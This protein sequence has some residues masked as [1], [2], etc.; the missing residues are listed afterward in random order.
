MA[1]EESFKRVMSYWSER[2]VSSAEVLLLVGVDGG[3]QEGDC[4]YEARRT[5][6]MEW[7]IENGFELV[8]WQANHFKEEE[9]GG[10]DRKGESVDAVRWYVVDLIVLLRLLAY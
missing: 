10:E 9:S 1:Q 6:A 7:C 3:D 5:P 8:V 2:L 4:C